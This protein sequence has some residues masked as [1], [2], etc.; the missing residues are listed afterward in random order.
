MCV[1]HVL[2]LSLPNKTKLPYQLST[3]TSDKPFVMIHMDIWGPY[4]VVTQKKYRY[5]LTIVDDF[6]RATWTYLF[7]TSQMPWE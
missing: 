2:W 4:R 1:L 6:S 5:F 3:H 7:N